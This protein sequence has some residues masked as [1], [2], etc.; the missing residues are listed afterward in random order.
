[1]MAKPFI[2]PFETPKLIPATARWQL[3]LTL[4][5]SNFCLKVGAPDGPF[6]LQLLKAELM[7]TRLELSANAATY[8]ARAFERERSYIY[9][10][11]DYRL[12]NFSL[13]MGQKEFRIQN[14][15][16]SGYPRRMFIFMVREQAMLG[17]SAECPFWYILLKT[18]NYAYSY[19]Y[20]ANFQVQKL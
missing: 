2:P 16:I 9:P 1:M 20:V 3:D 13:P 8:V 10:F 4:N 11:I 18:L 7:I 17:D 15:T 6:K 14:T 19:L 12:N 5:S